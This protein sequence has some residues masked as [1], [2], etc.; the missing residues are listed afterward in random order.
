MKSTPKRYEP[1]IEVKNIRLSSHRCHPNGVAARVDLTITGKSGIPQTWIN[2]RL[3]F[4][5]FY[6]IGLPVGSYSLYVEG[7]Y[8]GGF[9]R[10]TRL[11]PPCWRRA[12]RWAVYDAACEAEDAQKK[13]EAEEIANGT[14][15]TPLPLSAISGRRAAL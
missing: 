13:R 3:V 14:R 10:R 4:D 12:A 11:I 5:G 7:E 2:C 15:W 8:R 9:K 6:P 1:K